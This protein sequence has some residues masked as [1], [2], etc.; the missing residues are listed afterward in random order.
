MGEPQKLTRPQAAGISKKYAP[1]IGI[2]VDHRRQNASEE[3]LAVNVQRLKDYQSRLIVLPRRS[4]AP[5]KDEVKASDLPATTTDM[6]ANFPLPTAKAVTEVK[7]ADMPKAHEG[8]ANRTLRMAWSNQ[9]H[10]GAREKR[11]R[12]KADAESAK[13]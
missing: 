9:R 1:T 4:N 3:S 11:V 8:G 12:D 10:Q 2:S 7:V 6:A 13:K 5:K